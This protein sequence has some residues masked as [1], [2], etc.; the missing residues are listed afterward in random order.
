MRTVPES[1]TRPDRP[2][3]Q[4]IQWG[5]GFVFNQGIVG[6]AGLGGPRS[7]GHVG[8]RG[9]AGAPPIG[10]GLCNESDGE[11]DDRGEAELPADEGL[12]DRGTPGRRG[13]QGSGFAAPGWGDVVIWGPGL[14]KRQ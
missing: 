5:L 4:D 8:I 2:V 10:Y 7:F 6:P 3:G 1:V 11:R 9:S 13:G 12:G 14:G